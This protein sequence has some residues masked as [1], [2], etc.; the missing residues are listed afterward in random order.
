M[1]L[2]FEERLKRAESVLAH[3]ADGDLS[4]SIEATTGPDDALG[5]LEMGINFL[6]V[7]LRSMDQENR[8]KAAALAAQ[9]RELEAKLVTIEQQAAS[10]RKLATPIVEVWDDILALPVIGMVDTQRSEEIMQTLLE[11]VIG[12]R[13]RCVIIDVTGMELVD[14]QTADYLVRIARSVALVGAYCV[15]SGINPR[16]A[17]TLV[18]MG[19]NLS[20]LRTLATL[21]NAIKDCIRHLDEIGGPMAAN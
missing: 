8:E 5:S 15:I 12:S 13:S 20:E 7:D 17:Q 2:N 16:I 10:I 11:R 6:I 18:Q 4:V 21:K 3:V 19:A 9:Q 1:S 14:T